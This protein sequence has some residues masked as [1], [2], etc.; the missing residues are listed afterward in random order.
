MLKGVD[1]V[2]EVTI[3]FGQLPG[4][5]FQVQVLLAGA[6]FDGAD[7]TDADL[8]LV[9]AKTRFVFR[10]AAV[11]SAERVAHPAPA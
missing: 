4:G 7:V 5:P 8:R 6:E 2:L 11:P 9:D 1:R 3:Q 10:H